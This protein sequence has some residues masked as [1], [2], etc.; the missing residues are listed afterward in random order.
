MVNDHFSHC[1]FHDVIHISNQLLH[2]A[3]SLVLL[4]IEPLFKSGVR[5]GKSERR[6][7]RDVKKQSQSLKRIDL[8]VLPQELEW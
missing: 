2:F 7:T 6:W 4:L 8:P 3:L 5:V 1:S